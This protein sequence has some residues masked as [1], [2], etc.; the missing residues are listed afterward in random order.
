MAFTKVP[1]AP[2]FPEALHGRTV[3]AV[4]WCYNGTQDG[5]RRGCSNPMVRTFGPPL[6]LGL[7][8]LPFPALQSFFDR[9]VPGRAAVVLAR[10]LLSEI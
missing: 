4:V 5:L 6:P 8:P 9:S 2:P 10:R 3:A 1:P 7:Q